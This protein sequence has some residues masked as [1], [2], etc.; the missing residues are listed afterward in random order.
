MLN[1]T[2]DASNKL[3][4]AIE[5]CL[6][7][8]S[9]LNGD[10]IDR[11]LLDAAVLHLHDLSRGFAREFLECAR[12]PRLKYIIPTLEVITTSA[13]PKQH[14]I[15]IPDENAIKYF[16]PTILPLWSKLNY[17]NSQ[18]LVKPGKTGPFGYCSHHIDTFPAGLYLVH[19]DWSMSDDICE[20]ILPFSTDGNRYA[21]RTDAAL[22]G[23][24]R[25][26]DSFEDLYNLGFHAFKTTDEQ[27]LASVLGNWFGMVERENWTID[28]NGIVGGIEIWEETDTKEHWE[29]YV[30][31]RDFVRGY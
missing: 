16:V 1:E 24:D 2:L 28:E 22:Y 17:N 25:P 30:I 31:K 3:V 15:S 6:P 12:N 27:N 21:R 13:L 8:A 10:S 20:S 11:D 4:E 18:D 7:Q 19:L 26:K 9:S 14:P 29:R 23:H 5:A